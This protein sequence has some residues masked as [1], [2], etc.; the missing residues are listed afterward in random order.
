MSLE[1]RNASLKLGNKVLLDNF[2]ARFASGEL[3]IILGP[4]GTGKSSLLK[5]LSLEWPTEA[6]LFYF[7]KPA[8]QWKVQELAASMGVLPQSSTLTFAFTVR[9]VVELGGLTL[10]ASQ[11]EIS[12]IASEKMAQT[13]VLHLAE[14]LYPSLSGGE[15]QRVHLA[16]VLT[17]L[18][19][20]AVP[21]IL[22]LD[23]PTS[24]LDIAHQHRTLALAKQ[25][26]TEGSA[27]IAVIHDLNL[28]AQYADKIIMLNDGKIAA[29]GSPE[30][31]LKASTI[32]EVYGWPVQ[33][34]PH[35]IH[36]HPVVVG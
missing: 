33:I 25:L 30:D 9:E 34:I 18:A 31:V 12:A 5:L 35:P 29:Q 20:S 4:N 36:N 10:T 26:A 32:N 1:I 8:N 13:D 14:R 7:G 15:K 17:Q 28:A 11:R 24:A 19:K 2:S 22:M 6:E 3:T 16:R 21:P 27:V 23:E